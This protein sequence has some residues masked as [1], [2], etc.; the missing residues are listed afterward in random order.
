MS[1][2]SFLLGA[3][4]ASGALSKEQVDAQRRA[5]NALISQL[6]NKALLQSLPAGALNAP[7]LFHLLK[8]DGVIHE[9]EDASNWTQP[10][11]AEEM[12]AVD[13]EGAQDGGFAE[14]CA[15]YIV[16][17][18]DS[19]EGEQ[20]MERSMKDREEVRVAEQRRAHEEHEHQI[21][22]WFIK[23]EHVLQWCKEGEP[24]ERHQAL[25]A[26][27]PNALEEQTLS[28]LDIIQSN[29]ETYPW[30]L[31]VSHRW[32][33]RAV[34]DASGSQLREIANYL[35]RHEEVTHVWYDFYWCAL[36][37]PNP[38]LL[39]PPPSPLSSLLVR[40]SLLPPHSALPNVALLAACH[41]THGRLW[42]SLSSM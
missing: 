31:S 2:E 19:T 41:S 28:Y 37:A 12:M 22:F 7:V 14:F 38:P 35:Q 13:M 26:G 40:Y 34:P 42:S 9:R 25:L 20:Y 15:R 24:L 30:L 17:R 29:H 18:L 3:L 36:R 4:V 33:D 23:R 16:T 11:A 1:A 32:E 21:R 39:Q 5:N 6:K 10:V 8:A 27:H